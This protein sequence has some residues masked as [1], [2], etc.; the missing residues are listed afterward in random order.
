[1]ISLGMPKK[2]SVKIW[3]SFVKKKTLCELCC[4]QDYVHTHTHTQVYTFIPI[5]IHADTQHKNNVF[6]SGGEDIITSD[7]CKDIWSENMACTHM[8][9]LSPSSSF[10]CCLHS[11]LKRSPLPTLRRHDTNTNNSDWSCNC[12]PCWKSGILCICHRYAT[13]TT[14]ISCVPSTPCSSH[15]S[16]VPRSR[17]QSILGAL[18]FH[19]WPLWFSCGH[20]RDLSFQP[21]FFIFTPNMCWTKI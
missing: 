16:L 21:I 18:R 8:L 3:Q 6:P 2:E 5:Y 14:E 19:L 15:S 12:I 10:S 20:S 11:L 9:I 7:M 13:A 4:R 17:C 1:M